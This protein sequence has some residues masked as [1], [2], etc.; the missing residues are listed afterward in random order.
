VPGAHRARGGGPPA[1]PLLA[2][3]LRSG[4]TSGYP[5]GRRSGRRSG[6]R[7]NR[8]APPANKNTVSSREGKVGA[9]YKAGQM[10]Q[11]N[12]QSLNSTAWFTN[13][14]AAAGHWI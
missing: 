2:R 1:D 9:R 10:G 4:G 5:S 6:L 11:I 12:N 8:L 7:S 3:S 13:S 14:Q